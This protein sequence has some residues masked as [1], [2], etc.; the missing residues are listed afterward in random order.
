MGMSR[1]TLILLAILAA[2]MLAIA[3]ATSP[4]YSDY[5]GIAAMP[6]DGSAPRLPAPVNLR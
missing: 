2:L 3:I 4:H 6:A 5:S 1:A